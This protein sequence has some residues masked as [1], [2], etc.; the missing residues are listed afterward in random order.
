LAGQQLGEPVPARNRGPGLTGTRGRLRKRGKQEKG[1]VDSRMVWLRFSEYVPLIVAAG[2]LAGETGLAQQTGTA[3]SAANGPEQ[4]QPM[5]GQDTHPDSAGANTEATPGAGVWIP[6]TLVDRSFL[7]RTMERSLAQVEMGRLAAQKSMS[8]DVKRFGQMMT[9]IHDRLETQLNPIAQRLGVMEPKG[10]SKKEKMEIAKMQA[11]SGA[12][13][14]TAFIKT[15]LKAQEHD[16]KSFENEAQN[17]R[18]PATQEVA[19]KDEATLNRRLARLQ[20]L[21]QAH[22]VTLESSK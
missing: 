12:D 6:P 10:P 1:K 3:G 8:D 13:F 7:H 14:D 21:A 18:D 5:A 15:M 17:G 16:I 20:Q 11:L 22:G 2:L 9:E 4:Q 19:A